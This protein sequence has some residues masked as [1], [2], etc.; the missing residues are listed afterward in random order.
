MNLLYLLSFA[1]IKV[2]TN[3]QISIINALL[4]IK[5]R[6]S[7]DWKYYDQIAYFLKKYIKF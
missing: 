4:A 3:I 1:A 2:S 7:I 5:K 6:N